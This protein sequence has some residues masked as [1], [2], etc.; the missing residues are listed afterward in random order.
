[1]YQA[2]SLLTVRPDGHTPITLGRHPGFT[3]A[4]APTLRF[5]PRIAPRK[6]SGLSGKAVCERRKHVNSHAGGVLLCSVRMTCDK[7]KLKVQAV[8]KREIFGWKSI[9]L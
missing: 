4:A 8:R 9:F 6:D 5:A 2:I 7:H 1:M 3:G